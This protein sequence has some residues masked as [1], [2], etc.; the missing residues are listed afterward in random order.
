MTNSKDSANPSTVPSIK[1]PAPLPKDFHSLPIEE[2]HRLA[3]KHADDLHQ[4]ILDYVNQK[5]GHT[6]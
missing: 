1:L 2:Q 4:N 6:K 3:S 5:F